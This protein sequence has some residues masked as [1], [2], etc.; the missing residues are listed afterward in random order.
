VPVP[1]YEDLMPMVLRRATSEQRVRDAVTAISDELHLTDEERE[2][3][4]PSGHTT[5]ISSRVQSAITYLVQVGLLE[6]PKRQDHPV[7]PR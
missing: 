5:L 7:P 3:A 2:E 4:I 6:R 1:S